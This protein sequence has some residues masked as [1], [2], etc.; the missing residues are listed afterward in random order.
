MRHHSVR[1]LLGTF[2][3]IFALVMWTPQGKGWVKT[4][5]FIPQILESSPV[6]P[7]EFVTGTPVREKIKFP[8]AV[9]ESEADLYLPHGS[10][11]HPAVLFYM[12]VVP[13]DRDEKR[14][15]DLGN[16]LARSGV[17]VMIPWLR[18][19]A[20]N[21]IIESDIDSLVNAFEY[22]KTMN[23][24]DS[25][26]VGMSGICTGAS[27]L[28]VAAQDSRISSNIKFL[29]FFAGYYD[30]TD[31]VRAVSSRTSFQKNEYRLWEPDKLTRSVLNQHLIEG[32][33][34]VRD[35]S[36]LNRMFIQ[37]EDMSNMQ[38]I[39]LGPE[40]FATYQ[41]ISGVSLAETYDLIENLSTSTTRFLKAISPSTNIHLLKTKMFI[42]HDRNDRLVPYE[43]SLRFLENYNDPDKYHYT[44]FSLFQDAVQVH[45]DE[46]S[47]LSAFRY[48]VELFKLIRHVYLIMREL[49]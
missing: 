9:G 18:T 12:G 34:D 8:I 41:L 26:R 23:R 24:V 7:Q 27:M 1:W 14:I 10:G 49:Q 48:S 42:M 5:L 28:A 19:Q 38:P 40:G 11:K 35:R 6:K 20:E 2:I 16:A 13:P 21:K 15:V 4:F 46:D 32:V 44:E 43:E 37:N 33:S 47:E 22:L 39:R 36:I 29:N 3:L 45:M 30:A 31:L 25:N 17:I